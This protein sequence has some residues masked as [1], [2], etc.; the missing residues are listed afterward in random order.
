MKRY[1]AERW[2]TPLASR[3]HPRL[4]LHTLLQFD[5]LPVPRA[6]R[7]PVDYVK[8]MLELHLWHSAIDNVDWYA[9]GFCKKSYNDF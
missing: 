2:S 9:N 5:E 3:S 7:S 6:G 1:V 8:K 4:R